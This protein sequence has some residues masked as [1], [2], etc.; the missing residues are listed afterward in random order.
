MITIKFEGVDSFNRPIFKDINSK[1]RYGDTDH[2]FDT[3]ATEGEVLTKINIGDLCFF[4]KRFGCEPMGTPAGDLKFLSVDV[5][6][7]P[8]YFAESIKFNQNKLQKYAA[9]ETAYIHRYLKGENLI[10]D[11]DFSLDNLNLI[12]SL[13]ERL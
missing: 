9:T 4:G 11:K 5:L 1:D 8:K 6:N 13:L 10:I 2:L 12:K 7:D 3:E